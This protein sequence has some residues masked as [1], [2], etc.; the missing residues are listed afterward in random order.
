MGAGVREEKE[1]RYLMTLV[2]NVNHI[3]NV[4]LNVP[5]HQNF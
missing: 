3:G 2:L 1:C 5:Y 4:H